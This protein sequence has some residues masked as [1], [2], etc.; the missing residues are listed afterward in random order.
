MQWRPMPLL[1][2]GTQ[3]GGRRAGTENVAGIAGMGKAAELAREHMQER[4][5][6]LLPIRDRL[7]TGLPAAVDHVDV[8]GH[9]SQRLPGNASFLVQFIEG[10][11]ML[12]M[13]NM[14]GIAVSSGSSCTSRALKASHVLLAMGISHEKAQGSL[15]LSAGVNNSLPEAEYVL[16]ELPPIV[17]RLRQM[18]PL[19]AKFKKAN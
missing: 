15:L 4:I 13:L 2:G 1:D 6:H 10:E 7:L 14:K 16:K 19:Y 18:S 5:S 11:S 9:P 8:S 17:D 3:E 12:M